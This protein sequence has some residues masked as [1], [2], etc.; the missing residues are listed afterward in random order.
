M[1][2][3]RPKSPTDPA[4]E[5]AVRQ[6]ALRLLT[7]R[8]RGSEDLARTLERRGFERVAVRAA[9]ERL[10][11]EGWLDDLAAARSVVRARAARYGRARIVREL[12]VLGFTKETANAAL[13]SEGA[14]SE[15][16]ALSRAFG[17]LWKRTKDLDPAARR[18]RVAGA[19]ARKG[20]PGDAISA[21]MKGSHDDEDLD[22]G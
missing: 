16:K 6:V 3:R 10:T 7:V 11:A 22:I 1:R 21:M 9:I 14:G 19:L 12:S 13:E 2:S 15:Q 4:S 18:R 8:A 20:F 17:A 5:S